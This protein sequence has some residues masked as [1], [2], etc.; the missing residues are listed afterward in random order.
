MYGFTR[1]DSGFSGVVLRYTVRVVPR[2]VGFQDCSNARRHTHGSAGRVEKWV[3]V[4]IDPGLHQ[5]RTRAWPHAQHTLSVYARWSDAITNTHMLDTRTATTWS[6]ARLRTSGLSRPGAF[7]HPALTLRG[8]APLV[9]LLGK[10]ISRPGGRKSCAAAA[11][12]MASRA[13]TTPASAA[14][15]TPSLRRAPPVGVGSPRRWSSTSRAARA[16]PSLASPS[17][18]VSRPRPSARPSYVRPSECAA[19]PSPCPPRP[20]RPSCPP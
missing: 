2:V 20:H 15:Q 9:R 19:S 13:S 1:E 10:R 17:P 14:P 8:L 16:S 7:T 4:Y 12:T 5:H 11:A 18:S 3:Y 6:T